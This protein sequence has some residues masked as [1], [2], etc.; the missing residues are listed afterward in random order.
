MVVYVNIFPQFLQ[1]V[2]MSVQRLHEIYS[3][4][5]LSVTLL[6]QMHVHRW[7]ALALK[8]SEL[9]VLTWLKSVLFKYVMEKKSMTANETP[10]P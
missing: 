6:E 5:C 8:G 10:V 4:N 9:C 3:P 1:L 7:K 2:S